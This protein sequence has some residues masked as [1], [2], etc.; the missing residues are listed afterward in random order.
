MLSPAEL[1]NPNYFAVLG[2]IIDIFKW[3]I[4]IILVFFGWQMWIRHINAEWIS[5]INWVLLEIKVPKDIY[6]TPMAMEM[7]LNNGFFQTGGIPTRYKRYWLGRVLL[8][9]SLEIASIEGEVHFFIRT[10]VQLR[11]IIETQIYSQYPHVEIVEAED[12]TLKVLASMYEEEWDVWGCEQHLKKDDA[13]P[14][15]TYADFGLDKASTK[16][17]E[18]AGIIDPIS[19]ILEWMGSIKKDEHIWFQMIIRGSKR[20]YPKPGSIIGKREEWKDKAKRTLEAIKAKYEGGGED[21]LESLGKKLKMS[22]AE[23]EAITAIERKMDKNPFDVGMRTMYLAKKAAFHGEHIPGLI[24]FLRAFGSNNLNG[25]KISHE[26]DFDDPWQDPTGERKWRRKRLMVKE[27]AKRAY[28]YPPHPHHYFTLTADEIATI[29]HFPRRA[30]TTPMFK[31]IE[32]KKAEP[33][34]NLPV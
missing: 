2:K 12:Y 20:S 9:F 4:P 21:A 5:Q 16:L 15:K 18:E 31:R 7:V 25:F 13:Y 32:S 30:S 1:F 34:V 26:T 6:K 3:I 23:Q 10:P 8:W 27:Y 11:N 29:Y 19:G 24:G 14:I 17:E 22:K 33:P 28:F